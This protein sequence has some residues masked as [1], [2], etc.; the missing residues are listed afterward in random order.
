[1]ADQRISELTELTTPADEDLLVIV[2]DPSG[3]PVTKKITKANLIG[4]VGASFW[5]NVPGS[6]TRVSDTQ[7]TI[8]DASNANKYEL[9]FK[10]AEVGDTNFTDAEG[11]GA[12]LALEDQ[13]TDTSHDYY[14]V[15]SSSPESAGLKSNKMRF[16]ATIQ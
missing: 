7:F 9:L 1:M 6:P 2:D 15:V 3:T 5:A 10:A 12:A 16:E 11:S 4:E 14:I 13:S 8:A